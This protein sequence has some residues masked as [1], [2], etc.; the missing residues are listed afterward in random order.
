MRVKLVNI[1]VKMVR[2]PRYVTFQLAEGAI[3]RGIY[4]TILDRIQR[5]AAIRPRAALI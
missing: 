5:F 2:H 4:R 1:G 3:P